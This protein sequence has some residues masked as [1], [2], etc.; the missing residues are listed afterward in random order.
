VLVAVAF[1]SCGGVAVAAST[2][3]LEQADHRIPAVPVILASDRAVGCHFTT[4]TLARPGGR[5]GQRPTPPTTTTPSTAT[6]NLSVE[7]PPVV[8]IHQRGRTLDVFTNTGSRPRAGDEF[9]AVD[10]KRSAPAGAALVREAIERC[11]QA[12]RPNGPRPR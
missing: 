5:H 8:L 12:G 4:V 7:I 10:G 11:S 1:A 3:P 9:Y 2:H 6:A